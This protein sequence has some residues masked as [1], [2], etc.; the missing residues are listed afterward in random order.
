MYRGSIGTKDV[1]EGLDRLSA[2]LVAVAEEKSTGKLSGVRDA[3]EQVDSDEGLTA[4][5][6][7]RKQR[8]F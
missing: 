1:L 8:P 5:G 2:Q 6:R 3:L 4:A 7:H